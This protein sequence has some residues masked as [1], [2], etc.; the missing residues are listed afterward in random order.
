[1][2]E[3][4]VVSFEIASSADHAFDTWTRRIDS[5]WPR[6]HTASADPAASIVLEPVLGGRLFER[7][8]DGV[9]HDWGRIVAWQPPQHFGYT[10][11]IRRDAGDATDVRITF[12]SIEPGHTRV[13]IVHTGWEH[14]GADAQSWRDR[15][16]GGWNGVIPHF[17][18]STVTVARPGAD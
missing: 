7:T 18:A 12:T 8:P 15:N 2:I 14:L 17:I 1:V 11:H 3:P 5:W 13:D 9:E 10:W 16:V 4:L 6:E